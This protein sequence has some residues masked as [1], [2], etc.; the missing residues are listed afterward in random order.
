MVV[1]LLQPVRKD[2]AIPANAAWKK[3]RGREKNRSRCARRASQ[4]PAQ[5]SDPGL[6]ARNGFEEPARSLTEADEVSPALAW[7][8]TAVLVGAF[9]VAER[10]VKSCI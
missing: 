8:P 6:R 7:K 9:N 4:E 5:A 10:Q 2:E 1:R 3:E